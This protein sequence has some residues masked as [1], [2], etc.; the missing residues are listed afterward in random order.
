MYENCIKKV[1]VIAEVEER[2]WHS[3]LG[4]S[5]DGELS[6]DVITSHEPS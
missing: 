2:C 1:E 3:G 6:E 5:E 4:G